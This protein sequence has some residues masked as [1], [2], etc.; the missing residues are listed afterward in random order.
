MT[1]ACRVPACTIIEL[2]SSIKLNDELNDELNKGQSEVFLYIKH[3]TGKMAKNISK[4][5]NM[6]F[7]TVD[8]HIRILLK[9]NLIERKGSKK[10]GG[11]FVKENN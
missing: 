5:L 10:T 11:Y 4:D 2:S 3:K 8:R 7:G 1:C 9:K 6:P